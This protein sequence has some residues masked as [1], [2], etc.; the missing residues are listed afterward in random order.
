L[1]TRIVLLPY[2]LILIVIIIA[3]FYSQTSGFDARPNIAYN[4]FSALEIA[5][6]D[7]NPIGFADDFPGG[8]RLTTL[9]SPISW[10]YLI[11]SESGIEAI[12][13]YYLMIT[14][15]II[16]YL[17]G[18]YLL[19]NSFGSFAL[20]HSTPV[21]RYAFIPIAALLCLSNG[22]MMNL[23]A[24]YSP[25]F[26]GQF[27]GFADGLR[28]GAIAFALKNKWRS[29]F[30]ALSLAFVVHPLKGISA[31]VFILI[32]FISLKPR[33]NALKLMKDWVFFLLPSFLW[34]F[35]ILKNSRSDV[36]LRDFVAWTR[37]FQVHWYPF[38]TKLFSDLKFVYFL[39]FLSTFFL[40]L[41]GFLKSH[42]VQIYRIAFL[43]GFWILFFI[44]GIGIIFSVNPPNVFLI[45]MSLIRFS[46]LITLLSVFFI[47][48]FG[49]HFFQIRQFGWSSLFFSHSLIYFLPTS[50]FFLFSP[51]ILVVPLIILLKEKRS[52]LTLF[53]TLLL[54][55]LLIFSLG[56]FPTYSE[57]TR[58]FLGT[59]GVS[60][61]IYLIFVIQP[62]NYF[63]GGGNAQVSLLVGAII[64]S[65]LG[66][67][68][69]AITKVNVDRREF[70]KKNDY[71]KVQIWAR[72]NT[73]LNSIF[74]VD[75][76]IDHGWRDFSERP[77]LGTP[78]EWFLTG[79]AYS[80]D[81]DTFRLG[82]EI[83]KSMSLNLDPEVL[84]PQSTS[85]VCELSR[86]AFYGDGLKNL[87]SV[88]KTF[89]V[90]YF[91]LYRSEFD[92]RVS[93]LPK[94]WQIAFQNRSFLVIE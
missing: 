76:C 81:V 78:R 92:E 46:E 27:Y 5:A 57:V 93:V 80:G 35:L 17:F 29:S 94:D 12:K 47:F 77:S 60:V 9:N 50:L 51:I 89:S 71:L 32:V 79:W 49:L 39:P 70:N 37:V 38:D 25:Y 44:S 26:H 30:I 4:G 91:V 36:E 69:W 43:N 42:V 21:N 52:K 14:L 45:Q 23:A 75:P 8:S 56:D 64:V 2:F 24:F 55:I 7:A 34:S 87:S 54:I 73:K 74:M 6:A 53:T 61:L 1:K 10:I 33:N 66:G 41:I 90:D 16:F 58:Y 67:V 19:W 88:S 59:L 85:K 62:G 13:L 84:G 65:M 11:A 86:Q 40:T 63:R 83:A 28:L 48:F 31:A 72:D 82:E 68:F 22:Q 20:S 15:E 3:S 18:C